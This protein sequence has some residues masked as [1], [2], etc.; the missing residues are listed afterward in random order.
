[1]TDTIDKVAMYLSGGLLLL[2]VVVT[3]LIETLAG[4][5]YSPVNNEGEIL[6]AAV[7]APN[8]R[9]ALVVAA[10]LVLLLYAI[11][12]LVTPI[13]EETGA[14]ATASTSD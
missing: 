2:G 4:Q 13:E 12:K 3:G 11:Y 8:I 7:F 6:D 5:P 10:L 14:T 1:M 9:T